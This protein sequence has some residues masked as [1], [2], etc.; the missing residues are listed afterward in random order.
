M[1]GPKRM[2]PPAPRG[3]PGFP[4]GSRDGRSSRSSWCWRSYCCRASTHSGIYL[5]FLRQLG[6]LVIAISEHPSEMGALGA[7]M[8]S[9]FL[10]LLVLVQPWGSSVLEFWGVCSSYSCI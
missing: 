3:T 5:S 7:F 9:R 4:K 1:H 2:A 6:V 8:A 10:G